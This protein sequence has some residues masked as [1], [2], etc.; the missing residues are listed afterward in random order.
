MRFR[1]GKDELDLCKANEAEF[2]KALVGMVNPFMKISFLERIVYVG[3][4][5]YCERTGEWTGSVMR[6]VARVKDTP[7]KDERLK[8]ICGKYQKW[9]DDMEIVK[10]IVGNCRRVQPTPN[11]PSKYF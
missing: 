5:V 3:H 6:Q 2:K 11:P 4:D 9:M 10:V 8:K 7:D 1:T